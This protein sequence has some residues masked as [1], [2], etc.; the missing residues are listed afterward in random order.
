MANR[1][2]SRAVSSRV[3]FSIVI[4]FIS[5]SANAYSQGYMGT[6]ST[7][8]GII[9][10]IS[11]GKATIPTALAGSVS[12]QENLT[13]AW[14]LELLG[15]DARH[16]DLNMLQKGDL[17]MGQG[18]MARE[19]GGQS[20][21]ASGSVLGEETTLFICS[22]DGSEAFRI[23]LSNSAGNLAGEFNS[24]TSEGG[25]DSGTAT[26]S[27]IFALAHSS[28]TPL[29]NATSPS[30]SGGAFVGSLVPG[31]RANGKSAILGRQSGNENESV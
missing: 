7:G 21:T 16:F 20:V 10:A 28:S 19:Q 26:G 3:I 12:S 13:G 25:S 31:N 24:I 18:K 17:I 29:G 11:V 5:L 1:T 30:A 6:V 2:I 14:T 4:L 8:A 23:K 9:P 15:A 22:V 27:I